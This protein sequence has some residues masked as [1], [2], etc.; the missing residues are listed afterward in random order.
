MNEDRILKENATLSDDVFSKLRWGVQHFSARQATLCQ[1]ILENYQQVAF[2]SVEELSQHSGISA[3]TV[4]RTVK[5]LGFSNYHE[6][7]KCFEKLIID[8]KTSI[9]WETEMSWDGSHE[10]IASLAW[11]S[12]DSIQAIRNTMTPNLL[13]EIK[14]ATD[15]LER[16]RRIY[17]IAVRSSRAVS[18]F[19]YCMLAQ[20]FDNI[21]IIHYGGDELYD[22]LVDLNDS[23]AIVAISLGG[24]H[25][26]RT[27]VQAVKYAHRNK[28]P[29]IL[30]SNDPSSPAVEYADVKLLAAQT[31]QHYSVIPALIIVETLL[32]ELGQRKK[33][34]AVKKLHRLEAVLTDE[35][36]TM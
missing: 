29:T 24:P 32:V 22:H 11:V 6:M 15:R 23:D 13:I 4:V 33:P 1:Y 21:H 25:Y 26:T 12:K 2:W 8:T 28:V 30:I 5:S 9:F 20:T 18:T 35:H 36:I 3:A 31:K 10:Q 17:I 16:A 27:T 7:L 34:A 19:F 14:K